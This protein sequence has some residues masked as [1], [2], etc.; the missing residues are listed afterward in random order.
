MIS[1][2]P[3]IKTYVLHTLF[4]QSNVCGAFG[5]QLWTRSSI[6]AKPGLAFLGPRS[7]PSSP[8]PALAPAVTS[9]GV[10]PILAAVAASREEARKVA[11]SGVEGPQG[12]QQPHLHPQ[13]TGSKQ[14]GAQIL[15]LPYAWAGCLEGCLGV[16]LTRN[17]EAIVN[18]RLLGGLITLTVS[19]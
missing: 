19:P 4:I 12:P 10:H 16:L 5:V 9:F 14:M 15:D 2:L 18:E 11:M 8:P 7:V 3:Q 1:H 17:I 6:L 13:A